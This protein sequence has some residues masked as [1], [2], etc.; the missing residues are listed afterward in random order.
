[1]GETTFT[2]KNMK[3]FNS[4]MPD[5]IFVHKTFYTE[6]KKQLNFLC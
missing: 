2:L 3:S 1:M 6:A 5:L 4:V